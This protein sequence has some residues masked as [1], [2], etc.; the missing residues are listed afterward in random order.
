MCLEIPF[1]PTSVFFYEGDSLELTVASYEIF[2]NAPMMK[3]NS[4]N[5]EGKHVIHMGGKYDTFLQLPM[6]PRS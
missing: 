3:D 4:L 1:P 5:Q 2:Q 6:I